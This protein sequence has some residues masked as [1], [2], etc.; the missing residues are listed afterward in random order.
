MCFHLLCC[1]VF[2]LCLLTSLGLVMER[3]SNGM[4]MEQA[5][6]ELFSRSCHFLTVTEGRVVREYPE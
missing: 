3:A 6:M 2:A 1:Y 5:K 4:K